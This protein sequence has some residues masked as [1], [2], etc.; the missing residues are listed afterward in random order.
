MRTEAP[1][2]WLGGDR[3]MCEYYTRA[4]GM[5]MYR[6]SAYARANPFGCGCGDRFPNEDSWWAHMSK[7]GTF[8]GFAEG[9]VFEAMVDKGIVRC[10]L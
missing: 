9:T 6:P 10:T 7:C 8:A 3:L 4:D 5:R 2:N 1:S